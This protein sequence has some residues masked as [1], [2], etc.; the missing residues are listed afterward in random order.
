M[1]ALMVAIILI[2][3]TLVAMVK[4]FDALGLFGD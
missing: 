1:D 3:A 4:A 2:G